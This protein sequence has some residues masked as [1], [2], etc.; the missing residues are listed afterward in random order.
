MQRLSGD[1]RGPA[2]ARYRRIGA[3]I[4]S[5]L[6]I[7]PSDTFRML[8]VSRCARLYLGFLSASDRLED[9]R[10][11]RAEGKGRRPSEGA[12]AKLERRALTANAAYQAAIDALRGRSWGASKWS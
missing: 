7:K 6:G 1:N 5:E 12:L 10:A 2:A 11:A 4:A 3:A 8:E 9:A